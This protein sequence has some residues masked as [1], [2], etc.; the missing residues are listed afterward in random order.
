MERAVEKERGRP[1]SLR[2]LTTGQHCEGSHAIKTHFDT[3]WKDCIVRTTKRASL[4][5]AIVVAPQLDGVV[6]GRV[7]LGSAL[8]T[9][10]P[11]QLLEHPVPRC[12]DEID[13]PV[14][15]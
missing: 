9:V 4:A 12:L 15:L 7:F 5:P 2:L 11:L 8:L 1:S 14:D 10:H 3:T 13:L 6:V